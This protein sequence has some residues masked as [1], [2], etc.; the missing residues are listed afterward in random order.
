MG[1]VIRLEQRF[2]G[3]GTVL[4]VLVATS[5]VRAQNRESHGGELLDINRNRIKQTIDWNTYEIDWQGRGWDRV[6]AALPS[7]MNESLSPAMSCSSTTNTLNCRI[8]L[9]TP[10][11]NTVT[12]FASTSAAFIS[13][14]G[15]RFNIRVRP[16]YQQFSFGSHVVTFEVA[17]PAF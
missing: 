12:K 1:S 4:T 14:H 6:Y 16:R 17:C 13:L 15:I 5:V 11:S 10:T 8:R 7:T 9:K 3:L 2:L